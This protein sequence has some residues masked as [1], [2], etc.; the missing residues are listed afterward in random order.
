MPVS[1]LLLIY[2]GLLFIMENFG[3][4]GDYVKKKKSKYKIIRNLAAKGWI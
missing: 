3:Q 4:V 1:I 2:D